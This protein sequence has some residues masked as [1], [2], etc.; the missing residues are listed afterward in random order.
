MMKG[1]TLFWIVLF[2]LLAAG[3]I[4]L[5]LLRGGGTRAVISVDGQVFKTVD[6]SAVAVPYEMTVETELGRNTLLVSQGSIQ[7]LEADCPGQDCVRQGAITDG[8]I[9][10]VCL[11]H[12]L[13]IQIE[14]P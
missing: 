5:S 6:L 7:V 4:G 13:V 1:K 9:P 2:A 11:P 10:I 8:A 12:K 3:G 14:E